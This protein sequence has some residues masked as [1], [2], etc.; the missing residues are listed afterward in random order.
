MY[1]DPALI[2]ILIVDDDMVNIELT[3]EILHNMKFTRNG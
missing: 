2:E 1:N 3:R